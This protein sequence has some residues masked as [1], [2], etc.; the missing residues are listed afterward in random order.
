MKKFTKVMWKFKDGSVGYGETVS[1]VNEQGRVLVSVNPLQN[2]RHPDL[3]KL[4]F[5]EVIYCTATWLIEI[6]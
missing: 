4:E 1:E 5:H 6:D 2:Y 3:N